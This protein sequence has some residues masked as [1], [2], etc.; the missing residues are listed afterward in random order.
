M[1]FSI[2]EIKKEMNKEIGHYRSVFLP[3]YTRGCS[4]SLENISLDTD[5][6]D[7]VLPNLVSGTYREDPG[8]KSHS[9]GETPQIIDPSDLSQRKKSLRF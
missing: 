5:F 4:T 3:V 6:C 1:T 8:E 7:G 9:H 2:K